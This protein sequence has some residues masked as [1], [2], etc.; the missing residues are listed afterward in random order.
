MITDPRITS[1]LAQAVI[2]AAQ[3]FRDNGTILTVCN[4]GACQRVVERKDNSDPQ[5]KLFDALKAY[6]ESLAS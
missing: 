1:D 4:R 5:A 6:E 2:K 3:E